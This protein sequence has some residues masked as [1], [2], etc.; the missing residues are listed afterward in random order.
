MAKVR[1]KRGW[2]VASVA[3]LGLPERKVEAGLKLRDGW[4]LMSEEGVTGME[5]AWHVSPRPE[6]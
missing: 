5:V 2:L 6:G 3:P 1:E 4:D